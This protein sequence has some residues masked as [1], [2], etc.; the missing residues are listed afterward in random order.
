MKRLMA[1]LVALVLLLPALAS[2]DVDL[3]G[4]S[5]DE[6]VSLKEKIDLALWAAEE[7]QEVT[8]PSG[9]YTVG[10]DIPVGKW[11]IKAVDGIYAFIKWGD[12]LDVSGVDI[13]F[14]GNLYES[15]SLYST[16]YKRYEEGKDKTEVT[17]DLKDG[18]YIIVSDGT[19]VFSPFSG[20]PKL[21]FK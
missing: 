16:S 1:V 15:E 7:W 14:S 8:V 17:Y 9:V 2:A 6:L 3:T 13:D 5:Y 20:G 10:V 11:T 19:V 4:M 18:Q 12:V 21:G